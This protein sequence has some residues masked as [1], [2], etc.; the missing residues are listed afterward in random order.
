MSHR[1]LL[2]KL[3]AWPVLDTERLAAQLLVLHSPAF[4]GSK[5]IHYC[6]GKAKKI[7]DQPAAATRDI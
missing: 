2:D 4:Q 1:E 7:V 5:I 3:K 6:G